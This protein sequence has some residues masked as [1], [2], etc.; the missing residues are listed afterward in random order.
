M[1]RR[2]ILAGG[3]GRQRGMTI[4]A[5]MGAVPMAEAFR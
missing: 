1:A 4:L 3:E 5:D 2:L